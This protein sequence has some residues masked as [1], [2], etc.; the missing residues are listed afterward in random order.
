VILLPRKFKLGYYRS[1]HHENEF[2]MSGEA[3]LSEAK[4]MTALRTAAAKM[5][6]L[7]LPLV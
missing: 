6:A 7:Q 2:A 3:A 4:R 5:A 1:V